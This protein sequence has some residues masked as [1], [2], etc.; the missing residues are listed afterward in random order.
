MKSSFSRVV[1]PLVFFAILAAA[2]LGFSVMRDGGHMMAGCFEKTMGADCSML[3]PLEH[4]EA[5]LHVVYGISSAF[6]PVLLL[7]GAALLLAVTHFGEDYSGGGGNFFLW[8]IRRLP[9]K[10]T[11]IRRMKWLALHEKRDPS[12][13]LCAA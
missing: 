5:H 13:L 2:L 8:I 9:E 7:L 11:L 10:R 1:F 6:F 4:F 12:V 3:S